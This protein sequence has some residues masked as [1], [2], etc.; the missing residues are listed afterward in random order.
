MKRVLLCLLA[1]ISLTSAAQNRADR[2]VLEDP[3]SSTLI[4]FGDPQAY[5][6][7]DI[8]QPIFELTTAWVADNVENLNIKALLC[9]G[10]LVDRNES[11]YIAP[12]KQNQN[13]TQMW[14]ALSRALERVDGKVP[15]IA[16]LG[17]HDYGFRGNENASTHY[18]DYF[19]VT[20][21]SA[22][23]ACLVAEY[24]SRT[25]RM[26]L[27]NAAF[28][29]TL[30]G[31]DRKLLV[32]CTEY[33]PCEGAVEWIR[34]VV[35]SDKHKDD[36]VLLLTH[37]YLKERTAERMPKETRFPICRDPKNYSGEELWDKLI[38]QESNIRFVICGHT[39]KPTG[40]LE[41]SVAWRADKNLSGKN[42]YQMMFNVQFLGGGW[43]G[44]GGDGWIRI[45]EFKPDGKTVGVRTYSPLFGSSPMTKHLAYRTASYD[46]FQFTIE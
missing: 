1:V 5:M 19:P 7:Y 27:E 30:P 11:N 33:V 22:L 3:G 40:D 17:N 31:W 9:T 32:I 13:S 16:S 28:E 36:V 34:G 42:V 15:F 26:D 4:L 18:P 2:V 38:S 21:N 29:F 12:K 41:D 8:N 44:N 10:D 35:R 46:Q 45:L 37:S 39:G 43:Q 23:Q 14:E 6:K 20:R 25:G 24:P